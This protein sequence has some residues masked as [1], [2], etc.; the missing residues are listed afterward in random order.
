LEC[1]VVG[2]AGKGERIVRFETRAEDWNRLL[3]AFGHTPLPPY[4]LKARKLADEP[5]DDTADDRE[6]YQ[7]VYATAPGSVAAPTAGLHFT[8]QLIATLEQGGVEF[9]R[10]TLHVGPGTFQPLTGEHLAAGQLHEEQYS[11]DT[12]QVEK[13]NRARREG[14]RVI[15]VGTT[16]VRVLESACN[17]E[18]RLVAQSGTT[19]LLIT[20]GFPFRFADA[21]ITNFHLP[22]SS[23]LLLICAFAGRETILRAYREAIEQ[24]YRFY[25]YGDAM[26]IL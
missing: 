20:S 15:P 9:A 23:L 1:E 8:E 26:L 10:V 3:Q 12:G 7:T 6:R 18:G 2:Y 24:D 25:S 13:I 11:L 21:M 5:P 16:S 22:R 19:R 4:I 17:S 14:R